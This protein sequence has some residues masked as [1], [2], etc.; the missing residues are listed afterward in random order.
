MVDGCVM[1]MA[2]PMSWNNSKC[3]QIYCYYDS[4]L[5][6]KLKIR[7]I[8][9]VARCLLN[10]LLQVDAI[11]IECHA[12]I[13]LQMRTRFNI[14][15]SNLYNRLTNFNLIIIIILC[16][17]LLVRQINIAVISWCC[18]LNSNADSQHKSDTF[19]VWT[20]QVLVLSTSPNQLSAP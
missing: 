4:P 1:A 14:Q 10:Q 3:R 20:K 6:A 8:E 19:Y 7:L 2:Q 18:F 16:M 5:S 13:A 12:C 9:T 15:C 11:D 17:Y